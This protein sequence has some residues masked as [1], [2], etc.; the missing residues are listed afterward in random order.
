MQYDLGKISSEVMMT[1]PDIVRTIRNQMLS[2]SD[3][4]QLPDAPLSAEKKEEWLAYRTYLR[5]YPLQFLGLEHYPNIITF[6][7]Q[8]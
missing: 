5:D 3:W 1:F 6:N 7:T 2:D 4:T 8:P